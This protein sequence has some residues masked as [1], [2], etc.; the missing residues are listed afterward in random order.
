MRRPHIVAYDIAD[1]RARRRIF[2]RLDAR[3]TALQR[4]VF[5]LRLTPRAARSFEAEL[6][7]QVS[8]GDRIL[9]VAVAEDPALPRPEALIV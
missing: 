9:V 6:R 5:L 8:R 2:K 7:A 3:G 1:D 4:S